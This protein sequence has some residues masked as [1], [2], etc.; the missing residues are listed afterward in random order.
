MTI[1]LK[2]LASKE[3]PMRISSIPTFMQCPGFMVCR[4]AEIAEDRQAATNGTTVGRAVELWHKG[5]EEQAALQQAGDENP[6]ADLAKVKIWYDGYRMDPRNCGLDPAYGEVLP[7]LQEMTVAVQVEDCYF[8]G[9]VDQIRRRDGKLYLW[10]LKASSFGGNVLLGNYALQL[11]FYCVASSYT[12]CEDVHPGGIVRMTSYSP[13]STVDVFYPAAWTL[14]DS[15]QFVDETVQAIRDVRRGK[16][17]RRPGSQ[18]S[19]CPGG[20]PG[21]CKATIDNVLTGRCPV[22]GEPAKA[23]RLTCCKPECVSNIH[24]KLSF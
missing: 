16:M 4:E 15:K 8:V 9:H 24:K 2:D 6:T 10:D 11:C 12:L 3:S 22:C 13:R 20:G 5:A 7:D 21:S 18:C 14:A 19:Y 1:K 23:G 17:I